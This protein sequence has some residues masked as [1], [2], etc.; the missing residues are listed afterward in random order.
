MPVK[1]VFTPV[2]RHL[3]GRRVLQDRQPQRQECEQDTGVHRQRRCRQLGLGQRQRH[4]EQLLGRGSSSTS[5]SAARDSGAAKPAASPPP[6]QHRHQLQQ[7]L[8][9]RR[10]G[11]PSSCH[12][13]DRLARRLPR[14]PAGSRP[15][16]S[17]VAPSLRRC[18]R[19]HV[20]EGSACTS[21]PRIRAV[22]ARHP[23][24][25]WLVV[26]AV[27]VI[28]GDSP[29]QRAAARSTG[30]GGAW[31]ASIAGVGR[32]ADA[33]ARRAAVVAERRAY[34]VAMVPAGAVRRVA[35]RRAS[36]VQHVGAARSSSTP[37][38]SATASPGWCP[39]DRVARGRRRRATA[40]RVGD[41]RRRLSPAASGWRTG[42]VVDVGEE[43][44]VVARAGRRD[45]AGRRRCPCD[46]IAR[47]AAARE[48]RARPGRLAA[49]RSAP[50]GGDD[51]PARRRRATTR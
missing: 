4:V 34:P 16:T 38:S 31:G 26:G 24:L 35:R 49:D 23:V 11:P 45:A 3:Q 22:V 2:G 48:R 33:G 32:H 40:L 46:G 21:L 28:G 27:A 1:K 47:R 30:R 18:P 29:P 19:R 25:Y 15:A 39:P 51:R 12:R 37:T 10:V 44:V 42:V 6:R 13:A 43:Q 14:V 9:T 8:S 41:R 20:R 50:A 36:R 5:G 7:L 17:P